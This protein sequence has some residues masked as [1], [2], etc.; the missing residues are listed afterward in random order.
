MFTKVRFNAIQSFETSNWKIE[1][2]IPGFSTTNS[3]KDEDIR[4]FESAHDFGTDPDWQK[5]VNDSE[6]L[7]YLMGTALN[8]WRSTYTEGENFGEIL[9]KKAKE[10]CKIKILIMEPENPYLN[11]IHNEKLIPYTEEVRNTVK[12]NI[13][14]YSKYSDQSENF[15]FRLIRNGRLTQNQAINDK[16]GIYIPHFYSIKHNQFPCWK[17]KQGNSLYD[18][19]LKEFNGLWNINAPEIKE[20]K[21]A[22]EKTSIDLDKEVKKA[23]EGI[24]IYISYSTKDTEAFKI[25]EIATNLLKFPEIENIYYWQMDM[26]DNIILY[27]ESTLKRC[28]VI[29]LFCSP[30]ALLSAVVENE[31]V[32]ADMLRKPIIPV[33]LD[34]KYIP[35]LLRSRLGLE[36][37]LTDPEK[38]ISKLHSL[39]LKKVSGD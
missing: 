7:L 15:E 32:A 3:E 10:G 21:V 30:N 18:H 26:T 19:L 24:S 2:S 17:L 13:E 31:W 34:P 6:E 20:V 4:F 8:G 36:F 23:V 38:N 22:I 16:Y 37:D 9:V 1:S 39:I 5:I 27:M 12:A 11:Q 35:P 25:Q 14:F 29:L 33:F 28:D